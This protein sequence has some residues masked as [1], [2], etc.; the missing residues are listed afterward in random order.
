MSRRTFLAHQREFLETTKSEAFLSGAYGSGKTRA[1]CEKVV[2]L[3]LRYPNNRGFLC[4]KILQSLKQTTLKTLL[5][6]DGDLP[7]VLPK[8]LIRSHNKTD[9]VITLKNGSEIIYGNMD[10]EFVKSMNLGWAAVDEVSELSQEEWN[11]LIGRQ[12]LASMP[13]RQVFGSTNPSSPL[14]WIYQRVEADKTHSKIFFRKS[15]TIDNYY[16]PKTYIEELERTLF[17]HF[18]QRFFLGEWVGS[19]KLVYENFDPRTH[20]INRF[21]IPK[22]WRRVRSVDFGFV[23]PFSCLWA[24]IAGADAKEFGYEPGDIIIYRELYYTQRTVGVN[25]DQI[26]KFSKYP[27]G[28]AE[29]FHHTVSDWDSGDRADLE[30]KGIR[31]IKADKEISTGIQKVKEYLGNVDPA[32]GPLVRPRLYIFK[33]VLAEFDPKIKYDLVTG[34]RTNA[35]QG[36]IEEFQAYSWKDFKPGE[37]KEEPEDKFNHSLDA[38]RYLIR[39]IDGAKLWREA[40]FLHL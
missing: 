24:A 27:D 21:E 10:I 36:L 17:G 40:K 30:A 1:L 5:D 16:L 13:V 26:I 14:H 8:T 31:T 33:D 4:R 29:K 11:A 7:P 22:N 9:R 32:A 28:E 2:L 38:L 12:R 6:G 35:P 18:Y 34:E 20:L 3:S 25:A 23:S 19:G 37:G 15:R 39:S